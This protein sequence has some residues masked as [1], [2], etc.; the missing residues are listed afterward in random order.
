MQRTAKKIWHRVKFQYSRLRR[1]SVFKRLYDK[2]LWAGS[3]S[4]SGSGSGL[5]ATEAIREQL[6]AL[7]LRRNIKSVLDLPCG[8]F[9]WMKHCQLPHEVSYIG[10]D[11]VRSLIESLNQGYKD[12]FH[13]F[14]VKDAV[15]DALPACDL[16]ICRQM[17]IHLPFEDCLTVLAN[18]KA[19]G[20]HYLLI[21]DQ[22]ACE[23]REIIFTGS[24]RPVN[25]SLP[26]FSLPQ[27]LE[28]FVDCGDSVMALYDL[29]T[30]IS[31]SRS[32]R[33]P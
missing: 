31:G 2:R 25:L 10:A 14:V 12:E 29:T 5:L 15:R 17:L 27:P 6:P 13:R 26:P 24:F 21:T 7:I 20:S 4:R 3:E 32:W 30:Q 33:Q 16:I 1:R 22:P 19:S 9:T 11:I 28:T 18:F 23:N 8:D